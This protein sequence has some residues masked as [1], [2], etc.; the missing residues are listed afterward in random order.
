[1][2]SESRRQMNKEAEMLHDQIVAEANSRRES[3]GGEDE[4]I[5]FLQ[6]MIEAR[7]KAN[8]D[9]VGD[10]IKRLEQ[11]QQAEQANREMQNENREK[12]R[13]FDMSGR[14]CTH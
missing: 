6:Q 4:K 5:A 2:Q 8:L 7:E 12:V 1:M 10:R 14:R 13:Q 11:M 9:A 3:S